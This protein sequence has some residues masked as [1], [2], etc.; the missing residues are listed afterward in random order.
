MVAP[1]LTP[2]PPPG[3]ETQSHHY[4]A[5]NT[6]ICTDPLPPCNQS[7]R[8]QNPTQSQDNMKI[9]HGGLSRHGNL[10]HFEVNSSTFLETPSFITSLFSGVPVPTW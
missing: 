8:G 9:T 1:P 4:T 3:L 2:V 10:G 6:Q 7:D 5:R